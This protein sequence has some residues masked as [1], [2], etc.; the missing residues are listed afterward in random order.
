MSNKP[1]IHARKRFM[2][3]IYKIK[4]IFIFVEC[5][6]RVNALYFNTNDSI[7]ID[8]TH[9]QSKRRNENIWTGENC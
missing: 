4:A 3:A 1:H 5:V 6:C 2:Y 7:I 9:N 8:A